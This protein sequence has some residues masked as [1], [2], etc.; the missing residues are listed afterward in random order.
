MKRII[1]KLDIKGPNLVKGINL[2]GLR[3]LGEPSNFAKEYYKN[4]IDE[5]IYHDCVASLYERKSF[6]DLITHTASNVFIPVSVGG[7]IKNIQDIEKILNAGADKVFINSA[8]IKK[9]NFLKEAT[10]KFGSSNICL[11]IEAIKNHNHEFICLSNYGREVSKR[12]LV[13]W[14]S[15]VQQLGVG[16]IILTSIAS[17]G[18]GNGFDLEILELIYDKIEVPFIMHG[19]AGNEKQIYEVLKHDKVSGVAVSSLLH[20]SLIREK[21]FQLNDTIEGNTQFLRS[22]IDT[23]NYKKTNISSIKKFLKK[24]GIDVRL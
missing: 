8:A 19:G 23:I 2:E 14:F 3:V 16:E 6:L 13:D 1:A 24:K 4:L 9:P 11:S 20:Y 5:I 12:K 18:M 10:K 21:S 17:E 7:G 22:S 15:E